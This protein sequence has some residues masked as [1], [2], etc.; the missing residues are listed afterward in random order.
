MTGE[1]VLHNSGAQIF[2]VLAE[3][4]VSCESR[5]STAGIF[6]LSSKEQC[7]RCLKIR[8]AT[9]HAGSKC[10]SIHFDRFSLEIF[11]YQTPLSPRLT[12]GLGISAV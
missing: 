7:L 11:E 8:K 5:D 9:G 6:G 4:R 3:Y 12:E 1:G 2:T 10:R